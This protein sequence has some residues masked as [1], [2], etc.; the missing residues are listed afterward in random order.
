MKVQDLSNADKYVLLG[1]LLKKFRSEGASEKAL[2]IV[3]SGASLEEKLGAVLELY[4]SSQNGDTAIRRSRRSHSGKGSTVKTAAR[5]PRSAVQVMRS[6]SGKPRI[7]I[8][9]P[10]SEIARVLSSSHLADRYAFLHTD[11]TAVSVD[12]VRRCRPRAVIINVEEEIAAALELSRQ[13]TLKHPELGVVILCTKSQQREALREDYGGET[14]HLIS[15]PLNLM[16]LADVLRQAAA[17]L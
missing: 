14:F 15:K 12:Q 9:D 17:P 6:K 13:L 3:Q 8:V 11:K 1:N 7:L 4:R 5:S 10:R 2:A 16:R